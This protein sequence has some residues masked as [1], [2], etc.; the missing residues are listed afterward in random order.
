MEWESLVLTR[1]NG[2][3]QTTLQYLLGKGQQSSLCV[4][5]CVCVLCS[6]LSLSLSLSLSPPLSLSLIV[7]YPLVYMPLTD[8]T[9][10]T[11]FLKIVKLM[12]SS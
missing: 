10:A 1:Q 5:V 4:C 7:V 2:L 9:L 12:S 8:P 11:M 3:S 6:P